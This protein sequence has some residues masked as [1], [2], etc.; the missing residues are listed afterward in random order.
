MLKSFWII[1]NK[2]F[3]KMKHSLKVIF[4]K[5]QVLKFFNNESLTAEEIELNTKEYQFNTVEEKIA[6]MNGLHA[7]IGWV[8]FCMPEMQIA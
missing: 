7:A 6:F 5:E 1:I 3:L 8:E 4:G 2:K